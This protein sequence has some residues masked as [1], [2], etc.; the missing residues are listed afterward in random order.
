MHT[1]PNEP[2]MASP[3]A[4]YTEY[5]SATQ[6]TAARGTREPPIQGMAES[7]TT[8]MILV[9]GMKTTTL[10]YYLL[11]QLELASKLSPRAEVDHR[12]GEGAWY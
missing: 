2:N 8:S 11:P 6:N 7:V 4:A 5:V 10:C 1:T 12:I 3:E 9:I